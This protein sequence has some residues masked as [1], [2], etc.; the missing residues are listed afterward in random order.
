MAV[1]AVLYQ[2]DSQA[3]SRMTSSPLAQPDAVVFRMRTTITRLKG[4][5]CMCRDVDL[6]SRRL[7]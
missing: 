7:G 6:V 5:A 3:C 2:L 1:Q 4:R